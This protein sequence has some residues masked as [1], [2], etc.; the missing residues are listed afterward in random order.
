MKLN[1][2]IFIAVLLLV[3]SCKNKAEKPKETEVADTP[4]TEVE[5]PAP[6][7]KDTIA[8]ILEDTTIKK[9]K[10]STQFG[11][12]IVM[13]Y[14]ETP[15][16]RDNF[17]KLVKEGFYDDLLFHR[18]IQGFMIQGGDP[19]SKKAEPGRAYGGGG[20]GYTI[21]AEI[22]QKFIHKKGALAAARMPDNMNP[23]KESSGSQFYIVHGGLYPAANLQQLSQ[24]TKIGYSAEQAKIYET[25][26]GYPP[27]D[28][29]YTVFGEVIKGL[30]VVDIIAS[31]PV[32]Q[33]RGNRPFSD[34]KF[35][36]SIVE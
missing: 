34:I 26:G 24:Q 19:E 3:A 17:V 2:S 12:M 18:V 31:Q 28:M 32:D 4:Q 20:P 9:A 27:L 30:N 15:N 1:V 35:K 25:I 10:I 14:N 23:A 13:L 33:R 7:E 16:H 8:K 22:N 21:P 5:T 29:Q 6:A 36:V 11:D